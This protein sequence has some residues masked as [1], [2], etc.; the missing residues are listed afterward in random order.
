[1]A[2]PEID[3]VLTELSGQISE[4]IYYRGLNTSV[5]IDLPETDVWPEGKGHTLKVM[6]FGR[7]LPGSP[8]VWNDVTAS[9]GEAGG[10]C[11]PP[12][13]RLKIN[14][15][16]AEFNLQ[17]TA[18]ESPD[19][20][21]NDLRDAFEAEEQLSHVTEVLSENTRQVWIDRNR[22]EYTRLA[23]H[24][25]I[26]KSAGLLDDDTWALTEPDTV[27]TGGMLRRVYA[28]LVRLGGGANSY[29]NVNGRP[30]FVA[31]TGMETSERI[32]TEEKFRQDIRWS[33]QVPELLAPLGAERLF[34][35]FWLIDDVFPPR[36]NFT[37]GAWVRV[38]AY[39]W[40]EDETELIENTDYDDAEFEDTIIFHADVF[41]SI[42][43]EP[44]KSVGGAKFDP[45]KYRGEWDWKN[46]LHREDNPDGNY[47]F[48]R[49][50]FMNG[51]KPKFPKYGFVLRHLRCGFALEGAAC[52][53]S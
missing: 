30:T 47:G 29:G 31:I 4:E 40:N 49:G 18:L 23:N 50:V 26:C 35:G 8:V 20:C 39:V 11:L 52:D 16:L 34:K 3:A 14:Q 7:S 17:Q 37:G 12:K 43:P 5:W 27:L 1:M 45:I 24:K 10:G 6:T 19:L 9:N 42:A 41:K 48:F 46:I 32:F 44:P 38:P 53:E 15:S 36:W 13:Q 28:Q 25:I 51:S 22:D 2:A 21:V 33:D